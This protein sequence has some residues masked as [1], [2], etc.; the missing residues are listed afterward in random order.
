VTIQ[1]NSIDQAHPPIGAATEHRI[2]GL[3]L[4]IAALPP[5]LL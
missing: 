2:A 4:V 3:T 5:S 1:T